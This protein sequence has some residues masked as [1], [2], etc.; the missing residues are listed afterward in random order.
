MTDISKINHS[1]GIPEK[2]QNLL[3]FNQRKQKKQPSHHPAKR[4]MKAL[5]KIAEELHKELEAM[6]SPYRLCI[7]QEG[8]D[9]FIDVVTMDAAGNPVQ[10]FRNDITNDELEELIRQIKSG[11]GLIFDIDV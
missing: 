8:E 10:V 2:R 5:T 6:D 4:N 11:R 1:Q 3:P 7:Y 9:I